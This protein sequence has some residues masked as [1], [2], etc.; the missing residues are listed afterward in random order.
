MLPSSRFYSFPALFSILIINLYASF[1]VLAFDDE[2][3]MTIDRAD[4]YSIEDFHDKDDAIVIWSDEGESLVNG[5]KAIT[6]Y[7]DQPNTEK[8]TPTNKRHIQEQEI[9][10]QPT[11]K[12]TYRSQ[13][14]IDQHFDSGQVIKVRAEY[15]LSQDPTLNSVASLFDAI[16]G[17]HLQLNNYCPNGWKKSEEWHLPTPSEMGTTYYVHYSVKCK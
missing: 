7:E 14:V 2:D 17:L 6:T 11:Q 3:D 15:K 8:T 9:G 4:S 5:N 10:L 13:T 16:G 12:P 1:S